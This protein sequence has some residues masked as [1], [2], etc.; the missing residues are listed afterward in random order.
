[1]GMDTGAGVGLLVL[2][3]GIGDGVGAGVGDAT[4]N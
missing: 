3:P 4:G 2:G 1:M